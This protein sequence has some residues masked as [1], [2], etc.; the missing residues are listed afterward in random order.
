MSDWR[1]KPDLDDQIV[2]TLI[3]AV[4]SDAFMEMRGQFI[5]DLKN[6][7]QAYKEEAGRG[8]AGAAS[9]TA[10]ALKGAAA[11]IG[12]VRLSGLAAMLESGDTSVAADLDAVFETAVGSL[13]G[14]S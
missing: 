4:G 9:Q 6:L 1:S 8:D 11:N 10:H 3:A 2:S 5:D 12:L 7:H 14:A 13:E